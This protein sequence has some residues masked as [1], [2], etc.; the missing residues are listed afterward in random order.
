LFCALAMAGNLAAQTLVV[1]RGLPSGAGISQPIERP[2]KGFLGDSFRVGT[3]G[4]TWIIDALRVWA[5]AN[6]SPGCSLKP[7][8][9]LEKIALLGALDN[10]PVPGQAECACHALVE[11]A[12]APG[13]R[14]TAAGGL[15]QIDFQN[16]RWS[17]PGGMDVLFS[18]RAFARPQA[19][20]GAWS[21]NASAAG[22]GY[23]LRGFD[24]DAVP[25][26]FAEN[27]DRPLWLNVQ[28]WAHRA[29]Q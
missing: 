4:E 15:W 9:W 18:V 10:P 7:G 6:S 3:A 17:V 1:D 19:A 2:G 23:R 8:D 29:S 13:V 16:L 27:P 24:K 20:C 22:S 28:V 11:V 21:L 25:E 12:N 14:L 5:E 26:G